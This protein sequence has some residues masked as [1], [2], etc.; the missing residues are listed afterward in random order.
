[1]K[2][3]GIDI[4]KDSFHVAW[5]DEKVEVFA[6]SKDGITTF[7]NIL[8]QRQYKKQMTQISLE[9][10]GIYHLLFCVL[11][12]D[13]DWQ[14]IVINPYI[15]SKAIASTLRHV[16]NDKKDALTIRKVGIMG[17]G[18]LFTDTEEALK[19]KALLREYTTLMKLKT[20]CKNMIMI[21]KKYQETTE[22]PLKSCLPKLLK[23]LEETLKQTQKR[24]RSPHTET[25][26]LLQSILGIGPICSSALVA[27]IGNISRFSRPEKLVAYIGLDCRVHQ[28]GSSIHGKGFL[29]KRGN[30]FLRSLLFNAAYVARQHNPDL[31]AF[32]EKKKSEGKHHFTATCAVERKLIHIIYAVWKRRT[33]FVKR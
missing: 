20:K 2:H 29:T 11:L 13:H 3:I 33:P 15:T 28:S 18:Y 17:E 21:Q 31:K 8:H 4:S 6:N 1:M 9:S 14:V 23:T 26:K 16:K 7:E 32:F 22:N 27:H 12:T 10:T 24:L 5:N 19:L 30:P 25:Q